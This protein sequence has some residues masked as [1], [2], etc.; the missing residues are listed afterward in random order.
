MFAAILILHYYPNKNIMNIGEILISVNCN[1]L[2][3]MVISDQMLSAILR[4]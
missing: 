2:V 1:K 4:Y 3:Y